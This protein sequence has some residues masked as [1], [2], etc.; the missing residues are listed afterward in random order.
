MGSRPFAGAVADG[1]ER[2]REHSVVVPAGFLVTIGIYALSSSSHSSIPAIRASLRDPRDFVQVLLWTFG[3][4]LGSY[5]VLS[6]S[7]YYYFGNTIAEVLTDS[8]AH[9]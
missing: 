9:S 3:C 8:F 6:I 2:D 5:L 4:I 1:V 7:A